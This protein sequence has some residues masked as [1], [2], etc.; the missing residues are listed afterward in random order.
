[1][2]ALGASAASALLVLGFFPAVTVPNVW[3]STSQTF[4]YTGSPQLYVVPEGVTSID[5]TVKGAQGL[6]LSGGGSGGEG[7]TV[8]ATVSV[9]PG[10]VLQINVGGQGRSN[11]TAFNG[12]GRPG[13]GGASDIRRPT[14]SSTMSTFT[15]CAY[16][17]NCSLSQRIVVAGGGGGGGNQ[18]GS[19]GGRGGE[20]GEAGSVGNSVG[21]DATGGGGGTQASG[22]A[23]GS[24]TITAPGVGAAS[25]AGS[26]GTGGGNGWATGAFG[27]GGAGGY[28]G[29]GQGGQSTDGTGGNIGAGGGGGGS[30]FAG[31]A[32]VT[33][34][35][36][37]TG[38]GTGNGSVTVSVATAIANASF[39][40]TGAAQ[41]YTVDAGVTELAVR[42]SGGAGTAEGDVV[43]GR[44]PVTPSQV[45][46]VNIGGASQPVTLF[47]GTYSGGSG[48]WNGG[49]NATATTTEG[50]TG[51]GGA[52]DIRVGTF[53]LADRVIVAGGGGGCQSFWCPGNGWTIGKGGQ[54][55][56][57]SGGLSAR[58][59][60]EDAFGGGSLTSGGTWLSGVPRVAIST[61]PSSLGGLGQGG[62]G[63]AG[64]GGGYYGGSGGN[65]GGGGSSY[66]TVTGPDSTNQ[67][68]GNVLGSAGAAFQH[69]RGGSSGDGIAVL[70]A[71]PNA[72][73]G[74]A[75]SITGTG[76]AIAGTVRP[77]FLATKP[78]VYYSTSESTVDNGGGS[79]SYLEGPASAAILA[80]DSTLA[81]SGALTGLSGGTTY[82]YRVC[83]R[84][85]AGNGCG[86]TESFTTDPRLT[87]HANGAPT[88]SV[89][90]SVDA[91]AGS[92]VVVSGN[93]GSLVNTGFYFNGWN[94]QADGLGT[95]YMPGSSVILATN[96]TL[97]ARW[98]AD[99]T[100]T[101]DGNGSTA[102]TPPTA[103]TYNAGTGACTVATN[104]FSRS[105]FT[106]SSWNTASS[107]TGTSYAPGASLA[108]SSDL[109]LYAQWTAS[110]GSSGGGT[111]PNNSNPTPPSSLTPP[112][113][114]PSLAPVVIPTTI[115]VTPG[116]AV[117]LTGD[118][119]TSVAVQS[120]RGVERISG[121]SWSI[122]VAPQRNGSR[123][124]SLGQLRAGSSLTVTGNGYAPNTQ[125]L[126]YVLGI[127]T[128][129][130]TLTTN[131][132]GAFEGAVSLP[133]AL[134]GPA[135][136]QTN[137]VSPQ[138][139][140]R[141]VSLGVNVVGSP[142]KPFR[143]LTTSVQFGIFSPI[144]TAEAQRT[145]RKFSRSVRSGR[146][147][148][149]STG[150]TQG[151]GRPPGAWAL[152]KERATVVNAFIR[153]Q[154]VKGA[155]TA[156]GKGNRGLKDVDRT[157]VV[158]A[159]VRSGS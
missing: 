40:F 39:G 62:E 93:S 24:G 151:V 42:L 17:F 139:A 120:V 29:G 153:G 26:L 90:S 4:T 149:V 20:D 147:S 145:L 47:Q 111:G 54:E 136:L 75:T 33:S 1:M 30:S 18:P 19:N 114:L 134:V 119:P 37:V 50:A 140:V 64:G 76:A 150:Y 68:V 155:F 117:V 41:T 72:T 146:P 59:T 92:T 91:V 99:L 44:L 159:K 79:V 122:S 100:L 98:T 2:R 53:G 48:G 12:G 112:S 22:G 65:A 9:N 109:V 10:E 25:G 142:P 126:V 45:L 8:T 74:A 84:S 138:L 38:G 88:G 55:A 51:G 66:A 102:G 124:S 158:V 63:S 89:P 85:V 27:G 3:S 127:S 96:L 28:W 56:D 82:Y 144:L 32:G 125:V 21:G 157:V 46:Q 141:S 36:F 156:Q 16:N 23:A 118:Q 5:V 86:A 152:S 135:V 95:T 143:I 110:G 77:R 49:G 115:S 106:F 103:C 80:G 43:Y 87:Y 71:M 14:F 78:A 101:Y 70:T 137:G 11:A 104:P 58:N 15:S 31:G 97:Y 35:A 7:A 73:S 148:I 107:G 116:R 60:F 113:T 121:D 94:T 81:V 105:G 6:T 83:A 108:P 69:D 67:G 123:T 133:S 132:A 128:P 57:G 129:I 34:G 52:S 130:G 13:G 154:G 131:A 61:P